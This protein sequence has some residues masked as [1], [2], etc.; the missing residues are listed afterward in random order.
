M[1]PFLDNN[2]YGS[3]S[4][5]PVAATKNKGMQTSLHFKVVEFEGKAKN[6]LPPGRVFKKR[7]FMFF[8]ATT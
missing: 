6:T 2:S 7:N 4:F 3:S 8:Q 1:F 5:Y